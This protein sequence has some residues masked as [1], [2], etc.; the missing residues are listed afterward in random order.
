M[1]DE[2][3]D[4]RQLHWQQL[5]LFGIGEWMRLRDEPSIRS[6]I[7]RTEN[8]LLFSKREGGW[9]FAFLM[10]LFDRL[11]IP[12]GY[13]FESLWLGPSWEGWQVVIRAS[14]GTE[15]MTL[16]YADH[17]RSK[18]LR[19]LQLVIREGGRDWRPSRRR[20]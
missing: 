12:P 11:W 8:Q 20:K 17:D 13:R 18:L 1:S 10:G 16:R 9:F 3:N 5:P 4:P 6:Q 2:P 7:A 15:Q 19:G 14:K